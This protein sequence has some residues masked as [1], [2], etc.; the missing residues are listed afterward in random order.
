M[1]I[2]GNITIF[3]NVRVLLYEL[4]RIRD[5]ARQLGVLIYAFCCHVHE[6]HQMAI[7][8]FNRYVAQLD[9]G[10]QIK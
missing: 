3:V 7:H 1:V 6:L 8:V 5:D 4:L 9:Y 2:Q 10:I